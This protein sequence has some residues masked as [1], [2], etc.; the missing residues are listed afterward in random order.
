VTERVD[1]RTN[2]LPSDA[3][4]VRSLVAKTG[5]FSPEEQGVAQELVDETLTR[6]TASGYEFLFADAPDNPGKLLGYTCYGPIPAT[7]SSYDLYW[8]AVTPAQQGKGL[9]VKLLRESER[10]A[11]RSGATLMYAETS[12]R[13]QY[14]PTRAFYER[15]GYRL[16]A[17]LK[18]F[19][20]PGDD[21]VIYERRL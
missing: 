16:A 10:L 15:N 11:A 20:A 2:V 13:R 5:F 12:G 21:K 9:G 8:I 17:L 14:E 3:A 18:D 1:W 6:G 7:Q 4:E 19:Y